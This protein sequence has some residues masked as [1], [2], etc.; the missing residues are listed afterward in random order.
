MHRANLLIEAFRS[1]GAADG[2]TLASIRQT[3]ATAVFTSL[4]EVPCGEE[5]PLA[6]IVQ[7]R[8]ELSQAGLV[9]HAA[10][11]LPV[12]EEI[13]TRTGDF[14]RHIENYRTSLRHLGEAGISVVLYNFMPALD[15][16]RTDVAHKMEDG[17]EALLFDPVKF[18]AFD[19]FVIGREGAEKSLPQA[20]VAA[21]SRFWAGLS[22]G[23]RT[24]FAQLVLGFFPGAQAT[25]SPAELKGILA[26]YREISA[27]QMRANLVAFLEAVAPAAE[28]SGVRMAIH[29]DDPPFPILGLPRIV[30]TEDDIKRILEAVNSPSNGLCYC[31]GSLGARADNEL[32][33]MVERYG[34]RIH[35][36]HLRSVQRN[37][38]GTFHEAPHLAGNANMPAIV[39]ALL[40]QQAKRRA[41]GRRDWQLAFRPDHGHVLLDDLLKPRPACPGYSL[42]GRLRGLAEIRGLQHGLSHLL[43]S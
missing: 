34:D 3:G 29:P 14:E 5:W 24:E 7:R 31:S 35:A 25:M 22:K 9:W 41:Q 38:D 37:P 16:V 4:H 19:L 21:A 11:S 32:V 26:R 13:K 8:D 39:A 20:E 2:V 15:W 10:E 42:L 17:A 18:A 43:P 30:S 1:F 23:K 36:V 27:G 6:S 28:A 40:K 33:G 12:S